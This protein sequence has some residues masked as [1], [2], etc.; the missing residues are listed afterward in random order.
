MIRNLNEYLNILKEEGELVVVDAQVD[1]NLEIAEIHRRV[2]AGGGPA[3]LFTNVKGADFPCA[4]NLFGNVKRIELAFGKRPEAFIKELVQLAEEIM[5]PRFSTLWKHRQLIRDG[6]KVGLKTVRKGPIIEC[7]DS[8]ARLN[9]LPMLTTW[10]EDGG[11]FVTLPLVYTEHPETG[12]HNLGMYRIQR[13]DDQHTGV[14]WQIQ[15]GGGFHY[16]VA[17]QKNESLPLSIFIGGPPSLMLSAIAPLP[18]DIPELMLAALLQGKKLRRVKNPM[19]GHPLIAEAD[20]AICGMVPPHKRHPE[21]PFGDHYGYYSLKHDYPIVN[22]QAVYHRKNAIYPATVV[23]KPRQEDFFLGDYI[24][25]LLSP[26]SKLVMPAI[27]KIW[28]YGE[29]GYHS[30]TATV[31]KERYPRE[32]MTSAFRILG[33]S[34]GQLAL[35]K[36]LL[37]LDRVMDLT[38]FKSVL[39]YVLE[40]T[41]FERDLFIFSNI[42]LDTL[43]YTGPAINEGS[44][45]IF[46][47]VGDPIRKLEKEFHGVLPAEVT[48]ALVY[49]GGCLVISGPSYEQNPKFSEVLTQ[50]ES[51]QNWPLVFLVDD[52]NVAKRDIEFLWSTFTRCEPAADLY[53]SSTTIHRHHLLYKA[54]IVLDCRMK[55]G[56]PK[57]LIVDEETSKTVTNRWKEYFPQK[58]IVGVETGVGLPKNGLS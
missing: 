3:L 30:L 13:Y 46:L 29:T 58:N 28:S 40:R 9:R 26:L 52:A 39:E 41:R 5:P 11:P 17:E 35:T 6:L 53:T 16:Y 15:K 48:N 8:P 31:V 43:D 36:F 25:S 7:C 14:H 33:E 50:T 32:A 56:Y 22:V 38:D 20:F 54:P 34:A 44:K 49:C 27:E 47:G 4:T 12:H 10:K 2:I 21:G 24:Q 42:A 55:P 19:G 57:E 45:A 51:L 18:E 1:P 37:V 23:G